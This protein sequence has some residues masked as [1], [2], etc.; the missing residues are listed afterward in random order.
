MKIKELIKKL[1]KYDGNAEIYLWQ[2]R[3]Y[4]D[5]SDFI[6][7]TKVCTAIAYFVDLP[8]N[9]KIYKKPVGSTQKETF[10][11]NTTKANEIKKIKV[12][13]LE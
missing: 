12:I 8:K 4:N 10:K 13:Y 1:K 2:G 11:E 9:N 5:D 3:Y 7:I 6:K